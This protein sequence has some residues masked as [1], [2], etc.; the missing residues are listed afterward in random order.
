M[1]ERQPFDMALR[2]EGLSLFRLEAATRLQ[3]NCP[4]VQEVLLDGID[5]VRSSASDVSLGRISSVAVSS[6]ATLRLPDARHFD[7]GVVA[8]WDLGR[9]LASATGPSAGSAVPLRD[10][11]RQSQRSASEAQAM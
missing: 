9:C 5:L 1:S 10:G 4:R 3:F 7:L 2:S 6:T 8:A 11:R